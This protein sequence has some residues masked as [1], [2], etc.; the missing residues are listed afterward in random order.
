[1]IPPSNQQTATKGFDSSRI[2]EN[3]FFAASV[4]DIDG[5]KNEKPLGI[6]EMMIIFSISCPSFLLSLLVAPFSAAVSRM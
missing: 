4:L 1:M 6:I 5:Y 2:L 3:W